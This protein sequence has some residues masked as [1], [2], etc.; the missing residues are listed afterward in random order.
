MHWIWEQK[1]VAR[2]QLST[3]DG[4]EVIIHHPGQLNR[5][6]GPDFTNAEITIGN[7]RWFGDVEIHW[8]P[9]DWHAHG[10]HQDPNYEQVILHVVFQDC[11]K[12]IRRSNGSVIPA[13]CLSSH[14]EKPLQAFLE[15]YRQQPKL[16]CSGQYSFIS[17]EAFKQQLE[18]AHK[19]YFEQKVDDL[20][21]YYDPTL[22]P[23]A[24]WQKML[25]I[26]LFDGLGISHNRRPMRRLGKQLFP[27]VKDC[28]SPH[29]LK[30]KAVQLSGLE[31][32]TR[33]TPSF[34]WKHRGVRP[35]N[36]PRARIQQ[37][38]ECL[39][40]IVNQPFQTWLRCNPKSF[41]AQMRNSITTTPSLGR[42]RSDIL[43]GTVFLPALYSLGNLFFCKRLKTQSWELWKTHKVTLPSSLLG[44]LEQTALPPSLYAHRLGTIHQLRS[45]CKP[46]KCQNC[47]VFKNVISS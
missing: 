11:G 2:H 38:A 29:Q 30:E 31:S 35:G 42:E 22:A 36:H 14:L 15:Q 21:E 34:T 27:Q 41:W 25:S 46:K 13:F 10:H 20:L 1:H 45:Y 5:S 37:G 32:Q 26:A 44:L 8:T 40:F 19:E 24:A 28:N 47:N 9:P 12:R 33:A 43:F 18:Q 16:P 17:E 39:W 3:T 7:L 4:K 6:D 23:S